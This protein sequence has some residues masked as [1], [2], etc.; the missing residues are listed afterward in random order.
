MHFYK[1]HNLRLD[2]SV[3]PSFT[4]SP[5]RANENVVM[6]VNHTSCLT[7]SI[8]TTEQKRA[9]QVIPSHHMIQGQKPKS[10]FDEHLI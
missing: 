5:M 1:G 6:A 10:H 4:P 7:K 3:T 9:G 2:F 8:Y